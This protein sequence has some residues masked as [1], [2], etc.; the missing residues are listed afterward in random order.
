MCLQN[1]ARYELVGHYVD[2]QLGSM[3][4]RSS[5]AGSGLTALAV[6]LR[7]QLAMRNLAQPPL[8]TV[9]S[10][11]LQRLS[12]VRFA[13]VRFRVELRVLRLTLS[14]PCAL[15]W[16]HAPARCTAT[17]EMLQVACLFCRASSASPRSSQCSARAWTLCR[18][19][20]AR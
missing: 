1:L 9:N 14:A 8:S 5:A 13:S 18:S 15:S 17:A 11:F 2:V 4:H 6:A 3:Q 16:H 12:K 20:T 10:V 7:W 19:C